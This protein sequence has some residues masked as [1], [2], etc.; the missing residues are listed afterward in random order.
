MDLP[1]KAPIPGAK[2]RS[3][4]RN[5]GL[6][7]F[8]PFSRFER[9]SIW[10]NS[11]ETVF[12]TG[13]A[14]F[15]GGNLA[16]ALLARGH[17][18][19]VLDDLST[20]RM[21]NLYHLLGNS[22]FKFIKGTI[23][24]SCLIRS[25]LKTHHVT[26]ISHQAAIPSV[27][28]SMQDPVRT[29]EA[30]VVG[31]AI[32]FDIAAECGC[33]RI[34]FASSSA[35]YGDLPELPKRE[36]MLFDPKSPYAVS[37]IAK[38]ML[39]LVFSYMHRLEIV[40]LRY[41]NV[42]GKNQDPASEYAAVIPKFISHALKDEPIPIEGDGLQTRDFVYIDDVV[43]ANV[44]ALFKETIP[45]S[46]FNIAYGRAIS[47]LDLASMIVGHTASRSEIVFKPARTGD[48]KH[49]IADITIARQFL[50]FMPQFD[51]ERGL[52]KTV[53]WFKQTTS[54]DHAVAV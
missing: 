4:I 34:V 51:I 30:N 44:N 52:A 12:V 24:D 26:R 11:M 31:T 38:E 20:G 18:V 15:I 39:A 10:R 3:A 53:D 29:M 36:N 28:K 49:S 45:M 48:I 41:F 14:G 54:P 7:L 47:I 1:S 32:L 19:V 25:I 21:A 33:K 23:L 46:V 37:K 5:E 2:S 16:E 42:Y 50:D 9:D 22:N 6:N 27:S 40:G 8:E 13:G 35:A 17:A 43:Q